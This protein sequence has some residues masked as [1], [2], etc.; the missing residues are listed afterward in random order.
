MAAPVLT[1][2]HNDALEALWLRFEELGLNDAPVVDEDGRPVGTVS[3]ADVI[4]AVKHRRAPDGSALADA[5]T[6][7]NAIMLPYPLVLPASAAIGQAAALLMEESVK[8]LLITDGRGKLHGTVGR[9]EITRWVAQESGRSVPSTVTRRRTTPASQPF[10]APG[11]YEVR[12]HFSQ[13]LSRDLASL[14]THHMDRAQEQMA[15][16]RRSGD[17]S[18]EQ[19]VESLIGCSVDHVTLASVLLVHLR[20]A[21]RLGQRDLSEFGSAIA[22]LVEQAS[23]LAV[24]RTDT[25][26]HRQADF[27]EFFASLEDDT[28][29]FVVRAV[30]R[31]AE[32]S[33]VVQS[34]ESEGRDN[35]ALARETL[36]VYVPVAGELG[37][38]ELRRRLEDLSFRIL[39][40]NEW[41]RISEALD[42]VRTTDEECLKLLIQSVSRFVHAGGLSAMV[43]ARTKGTYSLYR[44]MRRTGRSVENIMDK[45]GMRI[46]VGS[47]PDCY[48]VL[49][50]LHSH[51]RPIPGTFDDY[52]AVPKASG[53]RSLH[54]CV[55]PM[56]GVSDK[57]VEFQIRTQQMH[58]EAE[59]GLAAHWRYKR[60]DTVEQTR[61][62]QHQW[63][64]M[65]SEDSWRY[66]PS[67]FV[68][69][70]RQ[71]VFEDAVVVFLNRGGRMRLP[72][73]ATLSIFAGNHHE[74][75][76]GPVIRVNGEPRLLDYVLKD[77]DRVEILAPR[78]TAE[79]Q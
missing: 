8:Y 68:E 2:Q 70:L 60:G 78:S 63:L 38:R 26:E 24:L 45:L 23:P 61:T 51:F 11:N 67:V 56:H 27:A 59:F 73:G 66:S 40:P 71:R 37:F 54:T 72:A 19:V 64:E 25:A 46:I 10:P 57:P 44:K 15:L 18:V 49:G 1:A 6:L 48:A 14:C 21:G 42:P 74:G 76:P 34:I 75:E 36:D 28:R 55:L 50:L 43:S 7:V 5:Q 22:S 77:C 3:R 41:R 53:Y 58:N 13:Q 17:A 62:R 65:V 33:D 39:E 12:S 47:I 16:D 30:L 29:I 9:G 52:I 69:R 79:S 32:L 35:V 31:V 20:R 4:R